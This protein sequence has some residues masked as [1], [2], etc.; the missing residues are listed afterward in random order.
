[1]KISIYDIA[2][3]IDNKKTKNVEKQSG[4]NFDKIL[5][6]EIKGSS[7][8]A[9]HQRSLPPIDNISPTQFE[10]ASLVD[11]KRQN[12]EHVESFMNVLEDYQKQLENPAVNLKEL[13]PFVNRLEKEVEKI[14]PF[15]NSLP[16][17]DELK[18]V[19]NKAVIASTVEVIKFNRG[20][21]I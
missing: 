18:N 8:P 11:D 1:M 14:M 9:N 15:M 6:N 21:Y 4:H 16:D 17:N 13:A 3:S 5:Q 12:I 10:I 7:I 2:G 20:D 19:L